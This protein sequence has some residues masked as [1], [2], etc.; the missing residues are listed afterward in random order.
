MDAA[1]AA[2]LLGVPVDASRADIERAFR[3]RARLEH[4]DVSG[5]P[6]AFA[7][8]TE[9][10]NVLVRAEGWDAPPA[11]AVP[12]PGRRRAEPIRRPPF[13]LPPILLLLVSV[14]LIVGTLVAG[15][16]STSPFAPVEPLLRSVVLVVAVIGYAVTRLR[17]F[18]VVSG[19]AILA[20]AVATI[21]WVNFGTLLGGALMAPAIVLLMLHGRNRPL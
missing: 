2:R 8:V 4:P 7:A 1:T 18:G 11:A 20:T 6:T 19:V 9:A 13:E 21:A 12:Q 3:R 10:R 14:L 16:A 15:F 5:D 17:V